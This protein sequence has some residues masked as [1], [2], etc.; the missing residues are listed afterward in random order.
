MQQH[1]QAK[2]RL[3]EQYMQARVSQMSKGLG[4]IAQGFAHY[5]TTGFNIS[6]SIQKAQVLI[7]TP[8]AAMAAYRS[9]V[10]I[11]VIGP[12]L[13][14]VAFAAAITTGMAQMR[15]IDR[16]K[17][18][19]FELGGILKGRSHTQGG[20]LI[21]AEGDEYITNKRRVKELG[22]RFFDFV[23]FAPLAQVKS[24]LSGI[25]IPSIMPLPPSPVM[26]MG[27]AVRMGHVD[28]GFAPAFDTMKNDIVNSIKELKITLENKS[29]TVH[30]V[31]DPN[32]IIEG[33]DPAVVNYM[34]E[35]GRLKKGG[36]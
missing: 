6:K 33:A 19:K 24:A 7:E 28:A 29:L 31:I 3:E 34:S 15:A 32:E 13:A 2:L 11:P 9:L 30:N 12:G 17:P 14:K 1:A 21:E 22:K 16:Q 35:E 10:G 26:A 27:G 36:F 4:T 5:G 18:P 8:A 25:Q 20:I 23:N